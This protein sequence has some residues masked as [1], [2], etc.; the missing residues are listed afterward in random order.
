MKPPHCASSR[1]SVPFR[2][3]SLLVIAA[4]CAACGG[5]S[6]NGRT[7]SSNGRSVGGESGTELAEQQVLHRGNG[8]EPQTL[9]PHR[10]EGVPSSHILRDLF[11]GLTAEAP[12]GTLIPGVA[13]SWNVSSDG[14]I[15]TFQLR[16]DARWSNGDPLNATD[17][18]YG[19]RRSVDPQTLSEYSSI[20]YPIENAEAIIKGELDPERLG[21]KALD[22]YTLEIRLNGPT[23]Y[24]P[25][26]L[27]HSTTYPVHRTSVERHGERFSRPGNLVSN[28]A[29]Q[30]SEWVVQSHIKLKRNEHYWDNENTVINEVYFYPI[31]N[32][33][34]ELKRYR[35]DE[36]DITEGL[37][38]QQLTWI[39][40]NLGDELVISPYLGSYYFAYNV[41][42]PPFKDNIELRQALAMAI[43]REI[44]TQRIAGAGEI[45]AYGWVPPVVD[46]NGQ[47][48]RWAG[49]SQAE[50]NKEAL[51]LYEAAGYSKDNPLK[52]EVL[53]NTSENHKRISIAV[54]SMWKQLLGV[55]TSLVNQ[56]WKVFLETRRRMETT[57]V[58]R[59][60]WIGDYNDAYSFSQLMHS[61][62]ELNH[63]G[64]KNPRYDELLDGAAKESDPEQ[65]ARLMEAA[66]Q[67][68]LE[69]MPLVPIY[70]YVSKHLVKPWVGGYEPN[71]MDHHYAKHFY[72]L[73][74]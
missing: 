70:F 68:L 16:R 37:P 28:G 55:E 27:T 65:R 29:Y 14:K 42:Q 46:Y 34:A 19:F 73:E 35:A 69:D 31:E 53:Y 58:Y 13:E 11:E 51:R 61:E 10:A 67:I 5:E 64:Y 57:E 15:Y 52:V 6:G 2:I 38:Y 36:F 23:P 40:E 39:R 54:A 56:E 1:I 7:T 66:E 22:E 26:L 59:A 9:D 45:A 24:L 18:V 60:G 12:D 32:T 44:I 33:D 71:I 47:K 50:R 21:V 48:P 41:T 4:V 72:I 62:N 25:G 30:L 3:V 8:A 63:S 43:D 17:F 74:H 20:L 49:W